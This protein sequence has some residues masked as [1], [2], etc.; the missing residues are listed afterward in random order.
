MTSMTRSVRLPRHDHLHLL[1]TRNQVEFDI[2]VGQN[3]DCYDR[4]MCRVQEMRESLRIVHQVSNLLMSL[5][6]FRSLT[7][8]PVPQ[9]NADRCDQSRRPQ[10][11]STSASYDEGK[12]GVAH[13][14]L[15]GGYP[16]ILTSEPT[17]DVSMKALQ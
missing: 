6:I 4:Y 10:N 16:R 7:C 1:I 12:H 2:P 14:S 9:Q 13:P 8:S 5:T 11:L 17:S 15:Q 3:G